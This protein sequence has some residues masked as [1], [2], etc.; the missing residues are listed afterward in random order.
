[1]SFTVAGILVLLFA[2]YALL[3]TSV[4]QT[5]LVSY[6]TSR[7]EYVTGVKIQIGGVDF[8]PVKSLVLN[9]MLLKDYR[10]D[11]LL[12][13]KRVNVEIDSF[14]LTSRS[15]TVQDV[16]LEEAYFNLWLVRGEEKSEMN[17]DVFLKALKKGKTVAGMQR[18]QSLD[19]AVGLKRI[20]IRDS[21]FVY[22][23][24]EYEPLEYGINWTDVACRGVNADITELDFADKVRLKVSGLSLTEKSGFVLKE[25]NAEVVAS[26]STLSITK[27]EIITDRSRLALERLAYRWVPGRRDWRYFTTRMRQY[28]KLGPSSVSFVDLAYFNQRLLG[29]ENT[30]RCTGVVTNT[31]H[32]LE[33]HN[34]LLEFGE[35]SVIRGSF[36]SSG[37]PDLWNTVFEIDFEDT[38]LNP[39]D[40]ETIYLPWLGYSIPV[41]A[42]LHHFRHFDVEGKFQGT[43]EDFM[44]DVQSV[45]PG[46]RG[47]VHLDYSPCAGG[48]SGD[49][50]SLAGDF[51][52]HVVNFGK[53]A[54]V[55]GALL[56]WGNMS[57]S[58]HGQL[59]SAGV[60]MNARA[61]IHNLKV[62]T[63]TLRNAD[64][65]LTYEND[66]LNLISSVRNEGVE[67]GL[68]MNYDTSDSI[69]FFSSKG[70]FAVENL[71]RFGWSAT[72][73][74]ENV[75]GTFDVV[76]GFKTEQESFAHVNIFD[77][78][79]STPADSFFIPRISMENLVESDYYTT[80]L[81]SDVVDMQIEGHYMAVRPLDFTRKLLKS[82]LPAYTS[83]TMREYK[84][85]KEKKINFRYTI[86]MKDMNRVLKV[87]YPEVFIADGTQI[88]SGYDNVCNEIYLLL[89]SD[90]LR[91]G[92]W[93]MRSPK[94]EVKG[95]KEKLSMVW[96]ADEM[97]YM[98][99]IRVYNM[100]NE[101]SLNDN[102]I[103]TGFQWANWQSQT[104]SGALAADAELVSL[105]DD[106]Y[107]AEVKIH[108]GVVVMSDSIWHVAASS[109]IIEGKEVEV[110]NF[111]LKS[112]EQYFSVNGRISENPSDSLAVCLNQFNLTEFNRLV[113]GSRT[114]VFG[115]INGKVV[116]QDYYKD[117]LL[118]SDIR[119]G[120][121]GFNRDT[122]GTLKLMSFWDA[123]SNRMII[124]A[125]NRVREDVPLHVEGFYVPAADSIDVMVKLTELDLERVGRYANE[126]LKYS[127]GSL[128]GAL[129][130]T[131]T[132]A[133]PEASGHL[134][135]DSVVMYS[136]ELNTAFKVNDSV[137][138]ERNRVYLRDFV[139][140]DA[141][142]N[143]SVCSGYYS[144]A[145]YKYDLNITSQNFL[146]MNTGY[147]N[148]ELLY[149]RIYLSG[150]TNVNSRGGLTNVTVNARPESNS[151]LF[152]PLASAVSEED[153]NFLH[154]I[155]QNQPQHRRVKVRT[156]K[157]SFLVNANLELND[158]LKV[159]IVFD[160]TIGDVLKTAGK[161][162]VKI[163]L[164]QDG[165]IS[166]LGEYNITRGSYLFTL[167]GVFNK[168]FQLSPG[169]SIKWNGSP[170]DA[171]IDL[172]AVYNLKTSLN[173]LLANT[174]SLTDRSTK[175]PV[176]CIL[177]LSDN[178]SNPLV[179]FDIN[180]PSL[181][182]QTRSFIQSLFS[183]QDEI[184]KQIF[185]LLML[186]KFY[187]PDYMNATDVEERNM[188]YQAGVT[189]ATEMVSRQLSRWLSKISNNFDVDF[190]YRPGDNITSDEIELA[191]STQLLNDRVTLTANGNMDV[192][193][194]KD[195]TSNSTNN[196]NI[197]GDFDVDV[198]LNKQGTLKLKAYS[199]TD[200]K[201][202]YKNNA[203]TT[204]GV[205]I[206][207]QETFDTFKELIHKYFGFFRKQTK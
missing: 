173:E 101:F 121:W 187:K 169:G 22:K 86:D 6:F 115:M 126:H 8:R 38:H 113:L 159:Q 141:E 192:G 176:E 163:N 103:H 197:A 161:G 44:L 170:Y 179:K 65:F 12:Y 10:N 89:R 68:R 150:F 201:I 45:T 120:D 26:D 102:K 143:H 52:F 144:L 162:N 40:L 50:S 191:L 139:V 203:E 30:V 160:P 17:L 105:P 181:D 82:Y 124:R 199:H 107:R 114:D 94:I 47:K 135:L 136:R 41:P 198:K 171:V 97:D 166:M 156:E 153:G 133:Q 134:Y 7:I 186:N 182:S 138:I 14:R 110:E 83:E 46:M 72:G 165:G 64:V 78:F 80:S 35:N 123:D 196:N 146:L 147:E 57:G 99:W 195:I 32:R 167:G 178:L 24:Q 3:H 132:S 131:G 174:N 152:L 202:I 148:S 21:R 117:K 164:D 108:P 112:G 43:L 88:Y 188:G 116:V 168:N 34:L 111:L 4:V 27:G 37:L 109:M 206:S 51:N 19:W 71:N 155:S 63:S 81:F 140:A 125:E 183:S 16:T 137:H 98:G 39:N 106:R 13:C 130:I 95:D 25:L 58:Y 20:R 9:D 36:T 200:E 74:D 28:Y 55:N 48:Q 70:H 1:M 85:R 180:F 91:Y 53:L 184:N 185:S 119:V 104:Y 33:G 29:I 61:T 60:N 149:G 151:Q 177:N 66:R 122:L 49:C 56:G 96:K 79:Y 158:N 15:F 5:C 154:F 75:K 73:G 175:V 67:L 76:Y 2:A 145:D 84:K 62:N 54:H 189:T 207:Y 100:R 90:S 87:L 127:A 59:D 128:N 193:N 157:S 194:T 31:V 92:D 142:G 204:Q 77:L 69:A 118:Y 190:S 93:G 42:P 11:T 205:G 172:N 18:R 23:E 129:H